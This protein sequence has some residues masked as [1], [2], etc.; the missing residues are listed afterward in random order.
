MRMNLRRRSAVLLSSVAATVLLTVGALPAGAATLPVNYNIIAAAPAVLSPNSSPAGSNDWSC[1]PSAAHPRPVIL[2]NG[3]FATM[4]ENWAVL[5]PLLKN[6]GYCV[7]AFNYGATIATTL[8]WGHISSVGPI[9]TSAGQLSTFVNKVLA[10]TGKSK[11]DLVGHSQGGMMPNYYLKFLGGA[12]KVDHLVGL[13]PSNH[14]TTLSGIVNFE[15]AL[16]AALPGLVPFINTALLVGGLQALADQEVGS[17]F[18]KKMA[19]KPDTV[20]G[21]TYT[22]IATKYDEVVTPYTS[23]FLS[24][25]NVTNITL[26]DQC[27]LDHSEHVSIAF[28]HIA[29]RDVLNALDPAHA[30][31]PVCST[32]LPLIG[33]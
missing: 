16:G 27:S 17:S 30:V 32:V 14:G 12:A 24:G 21:V 4:G 19:T 5:S 10:S 2:V 20:A 18:M 1:K 31:A 3:T 26:Q 28:D 33:G 8:T 13:A 23:Q 7:Y 6:N 11:V 15:V 22:V 29:L 25:S 9:A